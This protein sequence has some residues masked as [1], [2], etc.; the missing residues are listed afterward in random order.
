LD[1]ALAVMECGTVET[2]PAGDHTLVIGEVLGLARHRPDAAPLVFY[3]G[4]Y[5]STGAPVS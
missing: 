4:G 5:L 2:H 1:G 3:E